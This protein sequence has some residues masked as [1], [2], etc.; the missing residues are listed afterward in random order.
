[1][2]SRSEPRHDFP[3]RFNLKGRTVVLRPL[4]T[5]DREPMV[6]F[7][8]AL[9]EDD[10]LFL[11]RD[12][13][14]PA[15]VDA[16]IKDALAGSLVT[17]VAWEDDVVVGYATFDRGGVRWTRHVAELRVVV[18]QSARGI[19][20]G[21]LLLEL[22][23]EMVL[24]VGVTKVVARM[25]PD[26]TDALSLFQRLGFAQEA[27]LRDHAMGVN[28]L[29]HDLLVLSFRTRMHQEQ[30]CELCG[31]PVLDALALEGSRLCTQCYEIRYS[32]LGGG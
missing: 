10:L 4:A 5:E 14:Q 7:A 24:D 28:G 18:A 26:Q 31:I 11:E 25:T 8:R 30:R 15:E 27:V 3:M 20:I 32:E 2:K 6:T 21:R 9:P 19:G 23:F 13:T 29:T 17:F 1:M 12:I 16:W 22:A